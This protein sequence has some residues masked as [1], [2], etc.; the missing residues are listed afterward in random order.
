MV[1]LAFVRLI[2]SFGGFEWLAWEIRSRQVRLV[3]AEEFPEEK[4]DNCLLT[5][6]SGFID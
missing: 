2:G 1:P 6:G 3:F 4:G 5:N